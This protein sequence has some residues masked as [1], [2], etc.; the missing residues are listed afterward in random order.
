MLTSLLVSGVLEGFGLVTLLPL[1]SLTGP[2]HREPS[3]L[4]ISINRFFESLGMTP[5]I[6]VLL[7]FIVFTMVAKGVLILLAMRQVGFTTAHVG[8]EL[9]LDLIRSLMKAR[10]NYFIQLPVGTLSNTL[11]SEA[12]IAPNT[13]YAACMT[14]AVGIQVLMYVVVALAVSFHV[15]L[16]ALACG[17]I[18][19]FLFGRFV[20]SAHRA[21]EDQTMILSSLVGRFADGISG[22]KPLK[23]MGREDRLRPLLE[24]ETR[25]LKSAIERHVISRESLN[26]LSEPMMV[27]FLAIGL[28]ISLSLLH[29]PLSELLILALLFHR[30]LTR[31][32]SLQINY[33]KVVP[34]EPAFWAI[35]RVIE[36]ALENSESWQGN[37][38]P[39]FDSKIEFRGVGFAYGE[40]WV[41]HDVDLQIESSGLVGFVGD[42]GAGKTTLVDLI[43]GLHTPAEGDVLVDGLS[44]TALDI[45]K[46]R[47]MIGYVPQEMILFN[48]SVW[49]NVSLGDPDIGENEVTEALRLSGALDFVRQMPQGI[50]T[51]VGERGIGLS[52]GQR[53][54]ISIARALARN[55]KLL[56]LDEATSALDD[57]TEESIYREIRALSKRIA[58]VAISH[59]GSL[60]DYADVVYFL[61]NGRISQQKAGKRFL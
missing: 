32:G 6:E 47:Q 39:T 20:R 45:F 27:I 61:E 46:W 42:S 28:W 40:K 30:I 21:G 25:D 8:T 17:G 38:I 31:I 23:A 49:I 44:M 33:Q 14:L 56:I 4:T 36:K 41:L 52:G 26:A 12:T 9:R 58:V 1:L 48:D 3:S 55:P 34:S 13:F 10:W 24:N 15:A 5:S 59:K 54:R 50:H 11:S 16:A 60:N 22:I 51:T 18:L 43:T 37:R 29:I 57:K 7:G 35:R 53:Q 19:V 2:T